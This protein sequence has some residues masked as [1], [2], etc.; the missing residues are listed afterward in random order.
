LDGCNVIR[1]LIKIL[2]IM[3]LRIFLKPFNHVFF[4]MNN[5]YVMIY[6]NVSFTEISDIEIYNF[7]INNILILL[8]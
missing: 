1:K 3:K 8:K 5:Y 6:K 4:Q 7:K 2:R